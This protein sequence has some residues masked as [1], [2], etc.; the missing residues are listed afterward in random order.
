[1][2]LGCC[3]NETENSTH[4][5]LQINVFFFSYAFESCSVYIYEFLHLNLFVT[6]AIPYSFIT[7]LCTHNDHAFLF[8]SLLQRENVNYQMA[9]GQITSILN[10]QNIL[11]I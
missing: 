4:T 9:T 10:F 3:Q 6:F 2:E 7:I 5:H 1:M 8:L 11:Q